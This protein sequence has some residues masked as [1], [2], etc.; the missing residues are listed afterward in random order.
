MSPYRKDF[1]ET[2][3]MPFLIKDDELLNKQNEI[4][5]RVKNTIDKELDSDPVYNE[6]YLNAKIKSSNRKINTN[7]HNNKISKEGSQCICLSVILIDS[8]FREVI[9]IILKCF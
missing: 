5:K 1:D 4:L 6:K 7:F 8:V 3:Y 2:K 9:I